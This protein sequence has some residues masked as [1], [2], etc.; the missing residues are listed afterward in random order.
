MSDPFPTIKICVIEDSEIHAA[1]LKLELESDFTFHVL[2]MD[3]SAR[4]GIESV[5]ANNPDVLLL[6]FQ[7]EDMTGLEVAKRLKIFNS[8]LKI[9]MI[10][11]HTEVGIINRIINDSHIDGLGIKGSNYFSSN[12]KTAI[13]NIKNGEVYIDSSLLNKLRESGKNSSI[14]ELTRRE[15]E[16]FIQSSTGKSDEKIALDLCVALSYVKN[17]KS[18]IAKK[19]KDAN[20]HNLLYKLTENVN[21]SFCISEVIR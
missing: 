3:R 18:K 9:F 2:S 19:I 16:V 15:F 10:T 13:K 5:K 14:N 7:L 1:W 12:V 20:M 8:Q 11:A 4:K 17:I 6:D 21:P